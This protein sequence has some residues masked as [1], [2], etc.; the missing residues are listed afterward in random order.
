MREYEP[1]Q[2]N[3]NIWR[4]HKRSVRQRESSRVNSC[5]VSEGEDNK[6]VEMLKK[7]QYDLLYYSLYDYLVISFVLSPQGLYCTVVS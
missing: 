5:S 2:A 1:S 6:R 4:M 7:V 3:P